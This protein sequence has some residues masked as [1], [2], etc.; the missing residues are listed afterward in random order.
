MKINKETFYTVSISLVLLAAIMA[1]FFDRITD[2]FTIPM[3]LSILKI[4]EPAH[5]YAHYFSPDVSFLALFTIICLVALRVLQRAEPIVYIIYSA[6]LF[7]CFFYFFIAPLEAF[8]VLPAFVFP[9]FLWH[10]KRID[11]IVLAAIGAA[12]I[13]CSWYFFE[14]PVTFLLMLPMCH[15]FAIRANNALQSRYSGSEVRILSKLSS[16]QKK[17]INPHHSYLKQDLWDIIGP[18]IE[19]LADSWSKVKETTLG[20]SSGFDPNE[21]PI[22]HKPGTVA[23]MVEIQDPKDLANAIKALQNRDPL[24]S[25][26][27]FLNKFKNI[28]NKIQHACFE[29]KIE[30]IQAMV[31]D[32]LYE[33]FRCRVE[34]QK[35]AGIKFKCL[36]TDLYTVKIARLES[37]KNFDEIHIL[38]RGEVMET[39]TDIETGET[40]NAG[41]QKHKISEFWSFVRRPS[42]KT[43]TKPGLLEGNC[44]NCGAPISIGQATICAICSSFIRSGHY[45]WVVSKVTQACEWEYANPRL[46]PGWNDVISQDSGFTI[47]QIED[48]CAVIFWMLRLVERRR[49]LEPLLRFATAKCC[50]NYS[51]GIKGMQT[52]SYMEN[53]SFAS[54]TLKAIIPAAK[55]QR[56]YVLIVWSGLPVTITPQGRQPQL[57]RFIKPRRDV[58]VLVR[59]NGIKTNIDNA[60]SSAHCSKCGGPLTSNFAINCSYCNTILNDGSEWILEKIINEK[61][62]EFC[63]IMHQKQLLQKKVVAEIVKEKESTKA[64][65]SGRELISMSA[66]MLL[67]DGHIDASEMETL[68]KF[69]ARYEMPEE[70]L[71]GIVEAVKQ[72]ELFIPQP[73]DRKEAWA[74]LEAA[75]CMALADGEIAPQEEEYLN[76]LTKKLGYTNIELKMAIKKEMT[77]KREEAKTL[78]SKQRKLAQS[79][80]TS[81]KPPEN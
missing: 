70:S 25:E 59:Q 68:K 52:Y 80:P 47:H 22:S 4:K 48:R 28:F 21:L 14:K 79:L 71:A 49:I 38:V 64:V 2:D 63:E 66:Q 74:L 27:E 36:E 62:Q 10:Q 65:R 40:L 75:V 53:V 26:A 57:H 23:S 11:N 24:F 1:Y 30:T 32:A 76:T 6:S 20:E 54:A 42:A 50:E 55:C 67:A 61:S 73:E 60:L 16:T 35:E 3:V 13:A 77:R 8:V 46:V 43:L 45:D 29:Q 34:E 51:F 15:L 56:L 12:L 72:G 9:V 44:P 18:E 7:F 69:A 81:D 31:S 19:A 58:L 17:K 39:A 37:D 5:N 78:A 41:S 33:Q